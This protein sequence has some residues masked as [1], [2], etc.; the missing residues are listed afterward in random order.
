MRQWN[1]DMR[2]DADARQNRLDKETLQAPR[3]VCEQGSKF[4]LLPPI[5]EV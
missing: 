4:T 2:H 5:D 1:D 3:R